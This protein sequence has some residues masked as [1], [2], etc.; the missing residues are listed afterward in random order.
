MAMGPPPLLEKAVECEAF[1][2]LSDPCDSHPCHM[3]FA[4][5]HKMGVV[6]AF[7]YVHF[8]SLK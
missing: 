6:M 1:L 4:G 2:L 8:L 3:S 5:R 7:H